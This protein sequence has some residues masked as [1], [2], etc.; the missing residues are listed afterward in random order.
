MSADVQARVFEPFFTTKGVGKGTG[1][2]LSVVHGIVLQCGGSIEV[3]SE[4]GVGTTF[5]IHVPILRVDEQMAATTTRRTIDTGTETIL[6]VEDEE[7]IRR[8]AHRALA[9]AGYTVIEACDGQHALEVAAS[10]SAPI[11]LLITDV[12]MPNL[13]GRSLAEALVARQPDLLVLFTSGYTDDT[14]LRYGV[15]HA[16]VP[17]LAKPYTV[18]T[19]RRQVREVLDSGRNGVR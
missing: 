17:F 9:K 7:S 4:S 10:Y 5:D 1:L 14:V 15:Q 18:A 19:L 6:L 11:H 16:E 8:I 2:G 13:D 3:T 12:V